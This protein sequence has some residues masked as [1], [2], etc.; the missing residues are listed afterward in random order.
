MSAID[1]EWGGDFGA[2]RMT[3]TLDSIN[4][5]DSRGIGGIG[6]PNRLDTMDPRAERGPSGVNVFDQLFS[7]PAGKEHDLADMLREDLEDE[8]YDLQ[9]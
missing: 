6:S 8:D 3:D 5:R 9:E 2:R 1:G 4:M 7:Q